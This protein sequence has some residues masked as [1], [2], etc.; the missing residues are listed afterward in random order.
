MQLKRIEYQAARLSC[1]PNF[2]LMTQPTRDIM[3]E[4]SLGLLTAIIKFLECVL[5]YLSMGMASTSLAFASGNIDRLIKAVGEGS[6]GPYE[7][8]KHYLDMAI[9]EYDQ[10]VCDLTAMIVGGV[11][12]LQFD[13]YSRTTVRTEIVSDR[14]R[15]RRSR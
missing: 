13:A 6:G 3:Y 10:A 15:R 4:K 9:K 2:N 1:N 14:T 5:G 12:I 7:E 8:G 11:Y